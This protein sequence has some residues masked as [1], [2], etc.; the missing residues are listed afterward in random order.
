[1]YQFLPLSHQNITH[2]AAKLRPYLNY[3]NLEKPENPDLALIPPLSDTFQVPSRD[4][5]SRCVRDGFKKKKK[6]MEFSIKGP[7]PV[8]QPP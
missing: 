6:L 4:S 7:D 2:I 5:M 3:F 8:A 1:M